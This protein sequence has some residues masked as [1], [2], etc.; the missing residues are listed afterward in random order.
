MASVCA[1]RIQSRLLFKLQV[2]RF[3]NFHSGEQDFD[4]GSQRE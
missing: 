3:G 1:Y 2:M 4:L